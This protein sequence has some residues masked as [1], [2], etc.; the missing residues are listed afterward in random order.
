MSALTERSILQ[1]YE[2]SSG[3]GESE[4]DDDDAADD[5]GDEDDDDE[6]EDERPQRKR[7]A[8]KKGKAST[9]RGGSRAKSNGALL[10]ILRGCCPEL[11]HR[12]PATEAITVS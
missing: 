11:I 8:K 1:T 9:S 6:T 10:P 4:N 5:N 2:E 12:S 3:E 7:P